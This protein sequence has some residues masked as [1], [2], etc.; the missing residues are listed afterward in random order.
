MKKLAIIL[1]ILLLLTG[2]GGAVWWK[3]IRQGDPLENAKRFLAAGDVRAA[4]VELRTAVRDNP[5]NAEAHLRLGEL[6]L[7]VGDPIAAEKELKT[8][9]RLG[10]QAP[11]LPVLLAQ[12][13]L[14][15]NRYQDLL[16]EF[17]T[18]L[19]R[20]DQAPQLLIY[21]ALAQL[22]LKDVDAARASVI[23]A[24]GLAPRSPNPPL[25]AAR[26]A[27]AANDLKEAEAKVDRALELDSRRADALLLKAQ[28]LNARGERAQ[29]LKTLDAAVLL[30]P[31]NVP[32]RLE[33]ANALIASGEDAKAKVDVDTVLA[34]QPNSA[35]GVYFHAVLL[36]RAGDYAGAD[37][38]M[39]KLS[40]VMARFPRAY[41]F[42][43][44][45][46][47][48]LGQTEQAVDAGVRYLQRNPTDPDGIKLMA[49]IYLANGK[50]DQAQALLSAV[51]LRGA[52]DAEMLDLLGRS[53]ALAGKPG[54]AAQSFGRALQIAP[55]DADMLA[56]LASTKLRAGDA[57]GATED[58]RKSLELAP[59]SSNT[60]E[61]LVVSAL[62][63]GNLVE[64]KRAL[65]ALR[66][67]VGDTESVQLFAG[68]IAMQE[69]D[70]AG[71]QSRLDA[72]AKS[73][74]HSAKPQLALA[75]LANREAKPLE[76]E[77][78]LTEALKIEPA[79]GFALS[80]MLRLLLAQNRLDAA[81]TVLQAATAAAPKNLALAVAL[82]DM[83]LRAKA[84]ER[85]SAVLAPLEREQPQNSA[86]LGARA[87]V[88][89]AMGQDAQA[90]ETYRRIL[91]LNPGDPMAEQQLTLLLTSAKE[92][93][94]ARTLLRDALRTRPG[95][96]DLLHLLVGVEYGAGGLDG[97]LAAIG[98]LKADPAARKVA[99]YLT[100][101][102]YMYLKRY[103]DAMKAYQVAL[104][105]APSSEIA[106]MI[107]NAA[108]AG[109]K[110]DQAVA[111]LR[112]WLRHSPEDM[113][114]LFALTTLELQL[115]Q[116]DQATADIEALLQKQP[117]NA[118]ALNNLAW[119]YQLRGDQRALGLAEKAYQTAPST[120]TADT[121]GWIK[122]KQGD[123]AG[124]LQL[125]NYAAI[126][127][128][129][130]P[131]IKYHLAYTLNAMGKAAEAKPLLEQALA[132][133]AGFPERSD[134]KALLD[135]V[136]AG[137]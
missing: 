134:A 59:S 75:E 6:Q 116:L 103:D 127:E 122:A 72:A 23:E 56:R 132:S 29:A 47:F 15:Q 78:H 71:A 97:A 130:D 36:T 69:Q 109:G 123:A 125:L 119:I 88:Q 89:V 53:Y 80:Q 70:W 18:S 126:G 117:G 58:F 86:L 52:A 94:A 104:E 32:V 121:L 98:R 60:A 30:A 33:R 74:P 84:P 64:A 93:D 101:D 62:A 128:P 63:S 66:K 77:Q 17:P 107:A 85:A 22:S 131:S 102:L 106:L 42:Q 57:A 110:L 16:K 3:F 19:V 45:N 31:T 83:Q 129:N 5:S 13:Y 73:F 87:R 112:D 136:A 8:A 135:A 9:S 91:A 54:Q 26:I 111:A 12:A 79:N 46:K 67:Q 96:S 99:N 38:S 14:Q 82:A 25:A 65:E 41:Y 113:S 105:A 68:T 21:R 100:G 49:R 124:S 10:A 37:A 7:Q 108:I 55:N 50:A 118:V 24:E 133:K 114:A 39:Q 35:A 51:A 76:F 43:A 115:G 1:G 40:G 4:G 81:V 44:I 27:I 61:A 90:R 11:E 2:G 28:L 95:D 34:S 20:P 92:W 48:N 137:K 120:Q